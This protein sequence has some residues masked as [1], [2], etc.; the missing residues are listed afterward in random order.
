M[1]YRTFWEGGSISL[2][3]HDDV[4]WVSLEQIGEYDFAP[5]DIP[6]VNKLRRGEIG[7]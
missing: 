3:D 1:A 2:K 6:F 7:I 4:A 5:A